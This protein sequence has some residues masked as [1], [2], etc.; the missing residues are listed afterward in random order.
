MKGLADRERAQVLVEHGSIT[1]ESACWRKVA[2]PSQN[3]ARHA[4]KVTAKKHDRVV[5]T[6]RCPFSGAVSH[7]H[8]TM[9]RHGDDL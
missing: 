2:F 1:A 4:A 3:E 9:R 6:Y 7:W 5:D 8:L